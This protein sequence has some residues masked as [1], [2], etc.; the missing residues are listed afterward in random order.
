VRGTRAYR[1]ADV[2]GGTDD[3]D[4]HGA[5]GG[6]VGSCEQRPHDQVAQDHAGQARRA[7]R[8]CRLFDPAQPASAPAPALGEGTR[9]RTVDPSTTP[10]AA[11]VSVSHAAGTRAHNSAGAAT[12]SLVKTLASAP[13]TPA[14]AAVTIAAIFADMDAVARAAHQPAAA[15]LAGACVPRPPAARATQPSSLADAGPLGHLDLAAS[16]AALEREAARFADNCTRLQG[17]YQSLYTV[18][19]TWVRDNARAS[20]GCPSYLTLCTPKTAWLERA[21]PPVAAVPTE[22]GQPARP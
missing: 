3:G 16:V 12:T 13:A 21:A 8:R 5:R 10:S 4:R 17:Y 6:A 7:R 1:D 11:L 20:M 2:G 22:A 9:V 19:A 15:P 18:S 14:P